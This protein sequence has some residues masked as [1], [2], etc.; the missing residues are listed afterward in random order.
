MELLVFPR[1]LAECRAAL[2]ENAVVV[3]NGRVSVK[4]DEAARL[5]VEGVQPIETYDPAK[6]FGSNRA[7]RVQREKSAQG[8]SGYF[9]T[10]PS[11]RLRRRCAGWKTCS[12]TSLTAEP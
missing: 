8:A 7:E 3:A 5:I 4:E 10:V 11:L 9:L 12:A 2:Q 6:S 1:V